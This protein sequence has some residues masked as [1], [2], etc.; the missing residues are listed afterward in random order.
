MLIIYQIQP[1]ERIR[2][3]ISFFYFCLVLSYTAQSNCHPNCTLY[4]GT[5]TRSYCM[6]LCSWR[7]PVDNM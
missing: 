6:Q 3:C 7:V 4:F 1:S 5:A 2:F